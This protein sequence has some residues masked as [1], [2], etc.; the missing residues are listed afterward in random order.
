MTT[1]GSAVLLTELKPVDV[2]GAGLLPAQVFFGWQLAPETAHGCQGAI[3]TAGYSARTATQAHPNGVAWSLVISQHTPELTTTQT[4]EIGDWVMFNGQFAWIEK[5]IDAVL[6]YTANVP[7]VWA[8]EDTAPVVTAL[9]NGEAT[10]VFDAPTSVNGPWTF[11]VVQNNT[12]AGESAPAA[13]VGDPVF[14][15]GKATITVQYLTIGDTY[16]FVVNCYA[17]YAG[18]S[19]QSL[20]S[21][22]II[23]LPPPLTWGASTVPPVVTALAG[24]TALITFA[25]PITPGGAYDYTVSQQNLTTRTTSDAVLEPAELDGGQVMLTVN[26][27]IEGHRYMFTVATTG[28]HGAAGTSVTTGVITA[29]A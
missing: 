12:S 19:A 27:L 21:E 22:P 28:P 1:S 2:P 17:N 24:Q 20:P 26:N 14:E 25:P 10:I 13:V 15:D 7:M 18:V 4:G 23:A 16:T 9:P 29:I 8:A 5:G 6:R 11:A 3:A